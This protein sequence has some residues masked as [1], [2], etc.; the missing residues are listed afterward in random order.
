MTKDFKGSGF[1]GYF[2]LDSVRSILRPV[3]IEYQRYNARLRFSNAL[4]LFLLPLPVLLAAVFALGRGDLITFS[5]NSIAYA[6]YLG[7][8]LLTRFGLR[9]EAIYKRRKI[10][11]APTYPLKLIGA[12]T[13]GFAT[14]FTALFGANH[15]FPIAVG[16]GLGAFFGCYL[17]YGSDP[18]TAKHAVDAHGINTTDQVTSALQRAE[19][20]LAAIEQASSKIKNPE[21]TA[22]LRHIMDLGR[23]ILTVLEEDPRDLYRARKF[24][25][26]YLE[27]AQQVTQGYARTHTQTQSQ[28]L[29][30][31]FRR[32]LITIEDVFQEQRQKLL[33]HDVV[34]LDIQIEV[35]SKQL[36]HEG[37]V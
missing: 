31:N 23:Q 18:R 28:E 37:V 22:R 34:D 10:T 7:G 8:A 4:L 16:F 26:V 32:V 27:G 13:V 1:T 5:V 12:V 36:K 35:L 14:G 24:L 2:S 30:A 19:T 25:N 17:M 21:L 11:R 33:E 20:M 3:A 29:E 6:A 9:N 15:S